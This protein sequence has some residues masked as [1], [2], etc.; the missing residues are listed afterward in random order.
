MRLVLARGDVLG[1]S[2]TRVED[3]PSS[4]HRYAWNGLDVRAARRSSRCASVSESSESL[5]FS[6]FL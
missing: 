5:N 3:A 1:L 2:S 4:W 6:H